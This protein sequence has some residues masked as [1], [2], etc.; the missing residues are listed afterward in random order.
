M[1]LIFDLDLTLVDSSIAESYRKAGD[2]KKV[3]QVI[4]KFTVYEGIYDLLQYADRLGI[5]IAV[6]TSSP[7][8]YCQKVIEYFNLNITNLVCYH[9]TKLHKPH[10]APLNLAVNKFFPNSYQTISFGDR[11]IDIEASRA[12]GLK[13]VA[14]LWGSNEDELLN[15]SNPTH[16]IKQPFEAIKIIDKYF[17]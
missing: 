8:I 10:P 14:C 12:A 17:T 13:S 4:E 3:Y 16:I 15:V 11:V 2:W 6:V 7:S 5:P 9:D 1:G